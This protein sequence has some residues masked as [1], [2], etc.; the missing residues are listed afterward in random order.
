MKLN[1]LVNECQGT[2]SFAKLKSVTK[3]YESTEI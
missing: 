1:N 3:I 2:E